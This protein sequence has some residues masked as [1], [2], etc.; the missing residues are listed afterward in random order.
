M[1]TDRLE[2]RVA[3]CLRTAMKRKVEKKERPKEIK[4]LLLP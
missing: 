3:L 1:V 2:D 4:Y